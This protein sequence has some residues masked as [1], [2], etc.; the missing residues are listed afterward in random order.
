M[1][2]YRAKEAILRG[3]DGYQQ[4]VEKNIHYVFGENANYQE[5]V[6]CAKKSN[7]MHLCGVKYFSAEDRKTVNGIHFYSLLEGRNL[8]ASDIIQK[9]D[10]STDQKLQVI[11]ALGKLTNCE[12]L[13]IINQRTAFLNFSFAAGIRSRKR[14]FCVALEKYNGVYT[15]VSLLNMKRELNQIA[16]GLPVHCIYEMDDKHD[17]HVMDRTDEFLQDTSKNPYVYDLKTESERATYPLPERSKG[18]GHT[19]YHDRGSE[20]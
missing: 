17:L 14:I 7:F 20:R 9:R 12:N 19:H 4:I 11:D 15:P 6:I 1:D 2:K 16:K 3:F 5:I 13:R 10:G 18:R 8:S